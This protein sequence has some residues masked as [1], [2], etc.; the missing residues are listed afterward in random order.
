M[1]FWQRIHIINP[2]A[3]NSAY[4]LHIIMPFNDVLIIKKQT[5]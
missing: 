1:W 3:D 2:I 5:T 4:I